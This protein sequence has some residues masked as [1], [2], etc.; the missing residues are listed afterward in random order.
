M[1]RNFEGSDL[2]ST[3]K[4]TNQLNEFYFCSCQ[5]NETNPAKKYAAH[6]NTE[7]N[8]HGEITKINEKCPLSQPISSK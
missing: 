4:R 2:C 5:S 1:L 7:S 3:V 6:E 8:L